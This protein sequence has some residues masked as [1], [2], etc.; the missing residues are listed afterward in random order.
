MEEIVLKMNKGV[1][2]DTPATNLGPEFLSDAR[3][4][5]FQDGALQ[6]MP[7][8]ALH[9]DA[10]GIAGSKPWTSLFSWQ[11]SGVN[12]MMLAK[13]DAVYSW[14]GTTA[15]QLESGLTGGDL[16]NQ[17][18]FAAFGSHILASDGIINPKKCVYPYT[19]WDDLS[20]S[21]PVAQVVRTFQRHAFLLGVSGYPNRVVWSDIDNYDVWTPADDNEAGDYDLYES[22]TP[23]VG[24]DGLSDFF[25]VYTGTQIH[26]FQ[27]IGGVYVFSRRIA[28][29]DTGLWTK[30]LLCTVGN[31]QYFMSPT[32]FYSFDG[33]RATEIGLGIKKSIYEVID[34][35]N[36]TSG[37]IFANQDWGEVWFCLPVTGSSGKPTLA[38]IYNYLNNTWTFDDIAWWYGLSKVPTDY[39]IFS[40]DDYKLYQLGNTENGAGSALTGYAVSA[41]FGGEKLEAYKYIDRIIPE[42]YTDAT[43]VHFKV[44][45]RDGFNNSLTWTDAYTF[46]PQTEW[47]IDMGAQ[48]DGSRPGP[49]GHLLRIMVYTDATDTPFILNGIRVQYHV[50]GGR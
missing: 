44:G 9:Y 29:Y 21:P 40:K 22:P 48:P 35:S 32:G 15:T 11:Y 10:S 24:G 43:E 33:M 5:R 39:P 13:R 4:V 17:M 41:E 27:Y 49:G 20:D 50:Q 47:K 18:T 31:V 23:V 26:V 34:Q 16:T 14:D 30:R 6:K 2:L 37:F 45:Y 25:A 28:S 36:I 19:S 1:V 12:W 8:Y 7:G 42:I 3:H 38:C 46:N